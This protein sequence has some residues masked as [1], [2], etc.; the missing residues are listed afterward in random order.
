MKFDVKNI[1]AKALPL[2]NKIREYMPFIFIL[3]ILALFAFLVLRI[4]TFVTAEPSES[5]V[6]E[7]LLVG[8]P[9]K[10]DEE[11]VERIEKLEESNV[12]VKA[13]FKEARDNPFSE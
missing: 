9:V 11:A 13:L 4:R 6:T 3:V 8:Q 1:T 2:V 7:R 10:I 5:A 12:E